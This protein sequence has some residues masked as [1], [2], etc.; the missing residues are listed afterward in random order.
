MPLAH[1]IDLW[2]IYLKRKSQSATKRINDI[3][4]F[5]KRFNAEHWTYKS[6]EPAILRNWNTSYK[7]VVRNPNPINSLAFN[8]F[9]FHVFGFG[10]NL[11]NSPGMNHFEVHHCPANGDFYFVLPLVSSSIKWNLAQI[12]KFQSKLD[13]K[14]NHSEELIQL[15]AALGPWQLQQRGFLFEWGIT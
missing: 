1:L 8:V 4:N 12:S 10:D 14:L 3:S 6:T 15:K 9:G 7:N 13:E 11:L 5:M 2:M